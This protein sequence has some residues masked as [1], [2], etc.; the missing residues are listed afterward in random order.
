[1][2]G[3][4]IFCWNNT[5]NTATRLAINSLSIGG[6]PV[7]AVLLCVKR[8]RVEVCSQN[9][10]EKSTHQIYCNQRTIIHN[11]ELRRSK[12]DEA[13]KKWCANNINCPF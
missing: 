4:R 11:E 1:M 10:L 2:I 6:G 9:N 3:I 13:R 7:A 12:K 8:E 5:A